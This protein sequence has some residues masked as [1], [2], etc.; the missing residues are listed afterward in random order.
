MRGREGKRR[1]DTDLAS[2]THAQCTP[3]IAYPPRRSIPRLN[4]R[5]LK[6]LLDQPDPIPINDMIIP[7][8]PTRRHH[9]LGI[10]RPFNHF[11]REDPLEGDRR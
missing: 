10:E 7:D 8:D 3:R 11:A 6:H 5:H 9:L 1:R 4:H 2:S